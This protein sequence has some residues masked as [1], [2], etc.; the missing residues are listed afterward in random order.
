[1]GRGAPIELWL[2]LQ[3]DPTGGCIA[4]LRLLL[5]SMDEESLE[6]AVAQTMNHDARALTIQNRTIRQVQSGTIFYQQPWT[7]L[8]TGDVQ[9]TDR[10]LRALLE[11]NA[12]F[13]RRRRPV[14]IPGVVIKIVGGNHQMRT[15][16]GK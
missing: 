9:S 2:G 12:V 16:L 11:G 13:G 10:A 3:F 5:V 1:M 4:N 6:H 15:G 7:A 8:H 14:G